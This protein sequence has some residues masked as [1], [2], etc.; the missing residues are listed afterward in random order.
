[1]SRR[2]KTQVRFSM[3]FSRPPNPSPHLYTGRLWCRPGAF[4]SAHRNNF[5][6]NTAREKRLT[7]CPVNT[8]TEGDEA[9]WKKKLLAFC[10]DASAQAN[11]GQPRLKLDRLVVHMWFRWVCMVERLYHHYSVCTK[12]HL[13][14]QLVDQRLSE[15]NRRQRYYTHWLHIK[16]WRQMNLFESESEDR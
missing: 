5:I 4:V 2:R 14:L 16:P 7:E 6:R 15:S 8:G 12:R 13:P 9:P 11:R 10:S 1:M 3:R